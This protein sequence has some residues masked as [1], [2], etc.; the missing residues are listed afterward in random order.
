MKS[1]S[2]RSSIVGSGSLYSGMMTMVAAADHDAR[3]LVGRRANAA[4][5]HQ[6]DVDALVHAVRVERVVKPRRQLVARQADVHGDRLGA[7]EQPVE[8]AVEEGELAPVDAQA[9]PHAVAEHEAAIEHRHDRLCA[10]LQLAVDVDEDRR[11][12]RVRD[13]V[14]RL[15]HGG[16]SVVFPSHSSSWWRASASS[17]VVCTMPSLC[18]GGP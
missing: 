4:R 13:V 7:L 14:H 11:V 12:P 8:M 16:Y 3:I 2:P 15:G 17:L 9:L 10:R 1:L 6:P 5:H 18:S